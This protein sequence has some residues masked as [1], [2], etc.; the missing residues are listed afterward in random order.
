MQDKGWIPDDN[1]DVGVPD[2]QMKQMQMALCKLYELGKENDMKIFK[3]G[4]RRAGYLFPFL[5]QLVLLQR[6]F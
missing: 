1:G 4:G 5:H 3:D 2:V 6:V